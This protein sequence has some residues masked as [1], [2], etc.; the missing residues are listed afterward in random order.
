V[1]ETPFAA[2]VPWR[3]TMIGETQ[4]CDRDWIPTI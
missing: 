2:G 4:I 3:T 1:S